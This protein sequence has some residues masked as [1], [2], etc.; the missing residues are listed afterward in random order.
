MS[1]KSI[2]FFSLD[3]SVTKYQVL[4]LKCQPK[5]FMISNRKEAMLSSSLFNCNEN[6]H[7]V[8]SIWSLVIRRS[9]EMNISYTVF[10]FDKCVAYCRHEFARLPFDSFLVNWDGGRSKKGVGVGQNSKRFTFITFIPINQNTL[11]NFTF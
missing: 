1:S 8:F 10:S 9:N 7:L 6:K 11:F 5:F 4:N 2:M 3:R